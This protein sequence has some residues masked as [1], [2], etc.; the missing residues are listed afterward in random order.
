M[1]IASKKEFDCSD[2]EDFSF[3]NNYIETEFCEFR[4]WQKRIEKFN[5]SLKQL[6]EKSVNGFYNAV[7]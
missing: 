2:P 6:T 3:G 5:N 7:I 4:G 1:Q